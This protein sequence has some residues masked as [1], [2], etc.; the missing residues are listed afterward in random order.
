[1]PGHY[2]HRATAIC[3]SAYDFISGATRIP[4]ESPCGVARKDDMFN[5]N[6]LQAILGHFFVCM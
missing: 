6:R 3:G 1:M 5:L 2:P 4:S